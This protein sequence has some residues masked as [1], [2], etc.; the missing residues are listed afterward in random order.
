[1]DLR[2]ASTD[3]HVSNGQ[4]FRSSGKGYVVAPHSRQRSD[5]AYPVID[6]SAFS[7]TAPSTSSNHAEPHAH[8]MLASPARSACH[9]DMSTTVMFASVRPTW[10]IVPRGDKEIAVFK[11]PPLGPNGS[12]K[13]GQRVPATGN[14][15]DQ[16]NQ[17][18][19]FDEGTTFPPCIG[20]KGE[21]AFRQLM[22]NAA[23]TA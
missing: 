12:F 23:A 15:K 3:T 21:C 9:C 14:W 13:T 19:H 6:F 16:Y 22:I 1:M 5:P 8:T 2:C 20:R 7:V 10:A 17:V 18:A 4:P 11:R